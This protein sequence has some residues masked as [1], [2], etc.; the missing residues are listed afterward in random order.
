MQDERESERKPK[1][2]C[3]VY[4]P[5]T[6]K[7]RLSLASPNT[8]V[9][10][11]SEDENGCARATTPNNID[12]PP[13]DLEVNVIGVSQTLIEDRLT[14]PLQPFISQRQCTD[15]DTSIC[16]TSKVTDDSAFDDTEVRNAATQTLQETNEGSTQKSKVVLDIESGI[17]HSISHNSKGCKNNS[18]NRLKFQSSTSSSKSNVERLAL[19]G[20]EKSNA[21]EE[22]IFP[23]VQ[24]KK[25][26]PHKQEEE[27]FGSEK[28]KRPQHQIVGFLEDHAEF[29]SDWKEA[30]EGK[31][32]YAPSVLESTVDG[33]VVKGARR[34]VSNSSFSHSLINSIKPMKIFTRLSV[35]YST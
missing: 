31:G 30:V 12:L 19:N 16:F 5:R 11:V 4:P 25:V 27:D 1:R 17:N 9:G 2:A 15:F 3:R 22:N 10:S 20:S 35:D 14:L 18:A 13:C 23:Y 29:G 8:Q 34:Y 26:K 7:L 33:S 21:Q 24:Q 32:R 6:K 28:L